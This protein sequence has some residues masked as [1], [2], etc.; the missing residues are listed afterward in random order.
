MF[1]RLRNAVRALS[2]TAS[3]YDAA[4]SRNRR[5]T[6][7]GRTQAEDK[8]LDKR[9]R[10]I[11]TANS[12]DLSRNFA[13]A[14]WA[15]RKHL[16]YTTA[17]SFQAK[18]KDKAL[19]EAVESFIER[20]ARRENF[21]VARRHPLRRAVRIAEACRVKDG[22]LAWVKL[23]PSGPARGTIQAIEGDLIETP[24]QGLPDGF[25]PE[26]WVHGVR[27][28]QSGV[29][30]SYAICKR[31][32]GSQKE[33]KRI[34]QSGNVLF[35]AFYDRF[36][37]VRGVSPIASALNWFRDTYEG[38]EYALAKVKVAQLFGLAFHRD[39]PEPI[40]G[41]GTAT[42]TADADEDGTEDSGYEVDLTSGVYTL[43]LD[44]GDRVD[45][46]ES[47]TPSGET[48]DFLK[49]M[50]H[51]ALRSLDIPFSFFD[52]SFTNF[53]GSRGGLIQYLKSCKT[54]IQDLQDLLNGWSRWRLGLA[55]ADGELILPAG[56]AFDDLT[57]E[58]VPDGVP[59]W[60]PVKEVTGHRAAVEAGFTSP[61]R[62]CK[63]TGTDLETNLRERAEAERMAAE[64]GLTLSY[65]SMAQAPTS[66]T[67]EE[68]T[69]NG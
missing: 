5:R 48:V 34:V 22:D 57:W 65:S 9:K 3:G 49:L 19:N 62:V 47:K 14:A 27:V 20:A 63:E 54:K 12:R 7:T 58:W 41:E 11:L 24:T 6:V 67:I 52:E 35:H 8:I 37:Q 36:D 38:F 46:L 66:P 64:L 4:D 18:T 29:A 16:D 60:D 33:L 31:T 28:N 10:L 30:R 53:Y 59:W 50:I 42:A 43:D 32:N 17:F 68:G 2:T 44:P 40:F 56:M 61:Q 26:E 39:A 21:D 13:V 15:I 69:D 55:V 25:D 51:V 1:D 45:L 23:A